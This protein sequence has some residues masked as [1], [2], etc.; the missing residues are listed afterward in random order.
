[1]G[2]IGHAVVRP[3]RIG[4]LPSRGLDLTDRGFSRPGG[5]LG[6]TSVGSQVSPGAV[7]RGGDGVLELVLRC[8][9]GGCCSVPATPG[10]P[11]LS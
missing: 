7:V 11:G 2:R 6:R 10:K 3:R 1:M 8:R 5:F 9:L 4:G